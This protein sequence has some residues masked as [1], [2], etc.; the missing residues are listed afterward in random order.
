MKKIKKIERSTKPL[1]DHFEPNQR[2]SL[3]RIGVEYRIQKPSD[4]RILRHKCWHPT[5][6]LCRAFNFI[7]THASN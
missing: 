4:Y 3:L 2:E 7:A 5:P 1:I 6:F